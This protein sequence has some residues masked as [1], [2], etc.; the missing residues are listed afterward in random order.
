MA[1]L[2]HLSVGVDDGL[3]HV[4]K[5]T[6]KMRKA[7]FE[8]HCVVCCC[9]KELVPVG[10]VHYQALVEIMVEKLA[11]TILRTEIVTGRYY[12]SVGGHARGLKNAYPGNQSS[13]NA[14][15]LAPLRAASLM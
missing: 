9:L 4:R 11:R 8:P 15:K 1:D 3:A 10:R 7:K 2:D 13:G 6:I 14:T 5:V 12:V